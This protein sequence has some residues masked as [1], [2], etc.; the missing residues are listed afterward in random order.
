ML[1]FEKGDGY[2]ALMILES[3]AVRFKWA[4]F[5]VCELYLDTTLFKK[6]YRS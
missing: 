6:W 2:A 3:R 4:Y 1:E 5:M